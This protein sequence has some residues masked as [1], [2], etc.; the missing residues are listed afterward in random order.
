MKL[1]SLD[2]EFTGISNTQ[3]EKEAYLSEWQ[4]QKQQK[5]QNDEQMFRQKELVTI[6]RASVMLTE[7]IRRSNSVYE[8]T[9][10]ALIMRYHL[11]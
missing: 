4:Q 7:S 9:N 11:R 8:F 5:R 1:S 10:L 2:K 3:R 6:H